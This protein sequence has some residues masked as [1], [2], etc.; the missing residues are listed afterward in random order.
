MLDE[1]RAKY[2]NE[3]TSIYNESNEKMVH[4][5]IS[6]QKYLIEC[7]RTLSNAIVIGQNKN[8]EYEGENINFK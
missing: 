2:I 3:F 7:E 1:A 6:L 4:Y 5:P 8:K